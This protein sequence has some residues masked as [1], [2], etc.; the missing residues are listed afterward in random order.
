[1]RGP[2]SCSDELSKKMDAL[3]VE[4]PLYCGFSRGFG[5]CLMPGGSS[6]EALRDLRTLFRFGVAGDLSDG[7]LLDR[8]VARRDEAAEEAFAML[9]ERHG[10]MV[11]G[12]CRRLLSHAHDAED[13]FQATFLV[14]A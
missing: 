6:K 14:L 7:Q 11:M 13:A 1:M 12:V 2:C 3:T 5:D 9:V 4:P 10:A 8:F